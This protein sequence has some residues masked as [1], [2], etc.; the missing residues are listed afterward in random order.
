[1]KIVLLLFGG[2]LGTLGRYA[3]SGLAH[4]IYLGTFPVGTMAVNL[5]GSLVIGFLWGILDIGNLSV[6]T[7]TFIFI[8]IFGGF[9]TFSSYALET[10]T[11]FKNGDVKFAIGN[12]LVTNFLGLLFVFAGYI[13]AKQI[14]NLFSH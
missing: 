14:L 7:R 6:N 2:A 5:L 1:M 8:G 9:T 12:V 13:V 11:L 4:N 3:V 10:L